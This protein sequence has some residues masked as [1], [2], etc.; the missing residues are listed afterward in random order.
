LFAVA[1]SE[2]DR[3]F[4]QSK[5]GGAAACKKMP[6][7]FGGSADGLRIAVSRSVKHRSAGANV[8]ANAAKQG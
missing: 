3:S 2:I 1:S 6:S 8:A 5:T 4:R 7:R